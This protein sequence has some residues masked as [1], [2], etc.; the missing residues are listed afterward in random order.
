MK[1]LSYGWS[2]RRSQPALRDQVAG[3][4]TGARYSGWDGLVASQKEYLDEF[5]DAADVEL[6][7]DPVVQQAVRFGLFHVLQAGARAERR[8]IPRRG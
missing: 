3:A 8:A 4:L 6:E 5:W 1:Y 7:G 2:G